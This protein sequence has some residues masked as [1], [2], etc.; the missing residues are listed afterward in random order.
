MNPCAKPNSSCDRELRARRFR[1]RVR[2]DVFMDL[3]IDC[4]VLDL[5]MR[6]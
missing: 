2:F 3:P 5:Q 6:T 4:I 1:P